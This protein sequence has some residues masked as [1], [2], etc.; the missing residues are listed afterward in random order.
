MQR[1]CVEKIHQKQGTVLYYFLV[2]LKKR[3]RKIYFIQK[4]TYMKNVNLFLSISLLL[5]TSVQPLYAKT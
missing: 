3:T 1:R 5:A 2:Q 4:E